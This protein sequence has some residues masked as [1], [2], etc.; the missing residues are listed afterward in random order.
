GRIGLFWGEE[1]VLHISHDMARFAVDG[2]RVAASAGQGIL[3]ARFRVEPGTPLVEH[4][5]FQR[6]AEFY[7]AA[8]GRQE[9]G[10][11]LDKRGLARAIGTD[12]AKPVAPQNAGR[13]IT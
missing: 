6:R 7:G 12:N 13:E 3:E 5:H 9:A 8:I 4:G 1:E 2:E 11:E 10:E